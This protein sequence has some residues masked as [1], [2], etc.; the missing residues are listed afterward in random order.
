MERVSVGQIRLMGARPD[1]CLLC[2]AV[3]ALSSSVLLSAS[4]LR[5][6]SPQDEMFFAGPVIGC[7]DGSR[8]FTKDRLNDG[9]CDCPDGTDEPGALFLLLDLGTSACPESKF[10][11][12]NLGAKPEFVFSSRVNDY[13]CDCCDGSDE[14][15]SGV[16]CPNTCRKDQ[17]VSEE[18]TDDST[19]ETNN[20][21]DTNEEDGKIRVDREDLIQ[22]LRGLKVVLVIQVLSAML[23]IVLCL[24][25]R[26]SRFRRRRYHLK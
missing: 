20:L 3:L 4:P 11:C 22:K 9:F 19:S 24:Y 17:N 8:T 10:Y 26:R 7:R 1:G 6:V 14:Y 23:I 18:S 16:H 12:R 21:D 15:H 5:G 2:F 25:H 13:I